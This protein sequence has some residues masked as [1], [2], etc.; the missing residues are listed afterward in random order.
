LRDFLS[1]L[2]CKVEAVAVVVALL[3][4]IAERGLSPLQLMRQELRLYY[5]VVA[6]FR[7]VAAPERT[8]LLVQS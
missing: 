5:L 3:V 8:V 4:L 2:L 1:V 7:G 6:D